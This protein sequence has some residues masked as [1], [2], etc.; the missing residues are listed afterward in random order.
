MRNNL[1][2]WENILISHI[3]PEIPTF[4]PLIEFNYWTSKLL[5]THIALVSIKPINMRPSNIIILMPWRGRYLMLLMSK[6]QW[7]IYQSK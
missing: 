1:Q 7:T 5:M 2:N 6:L 4:I 3:C